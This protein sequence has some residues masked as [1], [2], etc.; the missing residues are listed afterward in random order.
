M[1][2]EM[3]SRPLF[4]RALITLLLAAVCLPA[5]A[6]ARRSAPTVAEA[7]KFVA[8]AETTLGELIVKANRALWVQANFITDDTEAI[9]AEAQKE[10]TGAATEFAEKTRR[11]DGLKLPRDTARKMQL[12]KRGLTTPAPGNAKERGELTRIAVSLES[13][14][15]KGKYCPDGPDKPCLTLDDLEKI[16]A[17]SRDPQELKRIWLGWH[18]IA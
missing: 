8:D 6:A 12:L 10:L 14:Y 13:D 11:Y 16:M 3:N 9:A 4:Y 7:Q 15:G 2:N 1:E 17:E 5:A 18:Q